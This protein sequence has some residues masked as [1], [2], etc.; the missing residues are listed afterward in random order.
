MEPLTDQINAAPTYQPLI[1][2]ERAAEADA[3]EDNKGLGVLRFYELAKKQEWQVRDLE[4]GE[5]RQ[6]LIDNCAELMRDDDDPAV[7][8]TAYNQLIQLQAVR[9]INIRSR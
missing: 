7:R 5:M 3:A 6:F 8:A 9:P 2:A 4:W 1:D